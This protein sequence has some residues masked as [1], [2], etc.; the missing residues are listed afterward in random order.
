MSTPRLPGAVPSHRPTPAG[1]AKAKQ[2]TKRHT[3]DLQ[4]SLQRKPTWAMKR[5]KVEAAPAPAPR[6]SLQRESLERS[7]FA[8]AT[9]KR[10]REAA[11]KYSHRGGV[12]GPAL[13]VRDAN[14]RA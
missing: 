14:A 9:A 11:R 12:K 6:A 13:G 5:G 8:S 7:L 4:A 10:V 3:F 1:S 2:A